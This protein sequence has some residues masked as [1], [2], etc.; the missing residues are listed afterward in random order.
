MTREEARLVG[1]RFYFVNAPCIHGHTAPRRTINKR[2]LE[3][4][5]IYATTNRAK[6]YE[7]HRQHVAKYPER[8]KRAEE[9]YKNKNRSHYMARVQDWCKRHPEVKRAYKHRRRT[10]VRKSNG[11]WCENDVKTLLAHQNGRCYWCCTAIERYEV[12]H[13]IPL[14]RGGSNWPSNICVACPDCNRKKNASIPLDF[15]C[16]YLF[17]SSSVMHPTSQSRVQSSMSDPQNLDVC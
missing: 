11:T 13:I 12:D 7:R 3:C 1:A 16:E 4:E 14:A 6:L 5:R 17:T 2:C 15:I 8:Q 10:Q 9:K